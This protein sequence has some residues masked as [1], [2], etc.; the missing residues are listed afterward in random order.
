MTGLWRGEDGRVTAF[1]TVLVTA[2]LS[3]AGLALD[4]GLALAT[5][6]D[7]LGAA[8]EA[9]RAGAQEIDLAAYRADGTLLLD[10][11]YAR[12]AAA[13]YLTASGHTGAVAVAGNTV[14]VTVTATRHTQL[15][16]IIGINAI[17]V[18]ATGQAQPRR[19]P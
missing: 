12:I 17:T 7:A 3:F 1:V 16:T 14:T 11:A 9:A 2:L 13:G 4:G 5:K 19:Q 8:R 18:T 6:V 10:P 15:L